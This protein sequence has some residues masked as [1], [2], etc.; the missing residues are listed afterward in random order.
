M[1]TNNWGNP[2]AVHGKEKSNTKTNNWSKKRAASGLRGGHRKRD[3]RLQAVQNQQRLPIGH[4]I[5]QPTDRP[6]KEMQYFEINGVVF[7]RRTKKGTRAVLENED[8][9]ND[10]VA[11]ARE[12]L[13]INQA[14]LLCG[15]TGSQLSSWVNK[16][17]QELEEQP[18]SIGLFGRFH[19]DFRRAQAERVKEL[20]QNINDGVKNWQGS[21]WLLERCFRE[22]FGSDAARLAE[23]GEEMAAVRQVIE[24]LQK[25]S[26]VYDE[27]G[28]DNANEK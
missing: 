19:R 13:V 9:Y 17:K 22:D 12:V 11:A 25:S 4:A 8:M 28:K 1:K 24:K 16:G 14:A 20:I 23:L 10:L 18:D 3:K 2:Y 6:K 7:R 27:K 15:I 26:D 5:G 21:A